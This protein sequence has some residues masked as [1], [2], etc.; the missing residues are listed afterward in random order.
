MSSIKNIIKPGIDP[1]ELA[2]EE[3]SET[4]ALFSDN[5]PNLNE[6]LKQ[7]IYNGYY[8]IEEDVKIT[9]PKYAQD[10]INEISKK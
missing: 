4:T 5:K 10:L 1:A 6:M 3:N 9:L 8:Q 2:A 7:Y